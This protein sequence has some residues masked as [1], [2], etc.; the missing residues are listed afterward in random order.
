MAKRTLFILLITFLSQAIYAQSNPK[1][2]SLEHSRLLLESRIKTLE[3]SLQRILIEIQKAKSESLLAKINDS[4]IVVT[5]MEGAKLKEV[6]EV[7]AEAFKTFPEGVKLTVIGKEGSYFHVCSS[8]ECGFMSDLWFKADKN[9]ALLNSVES[10]TA[11]SKQSI[12]T[13]QS[14]TSKSNRNSTGRSY[15]RGPR[16][17][18][19]YIN[20]NGKKTYVDRSN[21]R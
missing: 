4:S 11:I 18:C 15:I 7:F 1:I 19:Y 5:T 17:G 14:T 9:K 2:D 3:D 12:K 8:N 20:S 16:G 21:C 6:P 10:K 13:K